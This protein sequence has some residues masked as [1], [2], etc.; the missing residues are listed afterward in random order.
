M[1][2][3]SRMSSS[4]KSSLSTSTHTAGGIAWVIVAAV[5]GAASCFALGGDHGIGTG[6]ATAC[7][8]I[9]SESRSALCSTE[10][11]P[12][13]LRGTQQGSDCAVPRQRLEVQSREPYAGE[14]DRG[15]QGTLRRRAA[16]RTLAFA[17]I[18]LRCQLGCHARVGID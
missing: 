6:A 11:T 13:S 5:T 9:T 4:Q 8:N 10:A 17:T 2:R 16:L 12:S 18:P 7:P 14:F 15:H 3:V 1:L